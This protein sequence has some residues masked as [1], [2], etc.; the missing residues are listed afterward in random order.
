[1]LTFRG[2]PII[3]STQLGIEP[4]R[5]KI[6]D[7]KW[8]LTG[9]MATFRCSRCGWEWSDWMT[10]LSPGHDIECPQRC[11]NKASGQAVQNDWRESDKGK[12][13]GADLIPAQLN[14]GPIEVER[15]QS[16]DARDELHLFQAG[17]DSREYIMGFNPKRISPHAVKEF[18]A[19]R[20][21]IFE[22][23]QDV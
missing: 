7:V 5:I 22:V 17:S 14:P 9:N 19:A 6:I 13:H 12:L 1:M 11:G 10:I 8:T 20:G 23:P 21:I 3:W 15:W 2:V 18:L 4:S 16:S